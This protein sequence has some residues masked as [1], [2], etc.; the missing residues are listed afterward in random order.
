V[1]TSY[2]RPACLLALLAS[3]LLL[4]GCIT[5][6][7]GHD[8]YSDKA[9]TSVRAA[10]S[11]VQTARLVLQ[12]LSRH[13]ILSPY[14]DETLTA[15]EAAVG[16][17]STAFG[18]VQPPRGDDE[19]RDAVGALLSDAEDAVAHARIAARRSDAAGASDAAKELRTVARAMARAEKRLS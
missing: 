18:S 13:R 9:V 7:T 17:I 4:T 2:T 19:L 16:S 14:A 1:S 11:E 6:A 8:S 15:N 10:T 12:L 3:A 5:P